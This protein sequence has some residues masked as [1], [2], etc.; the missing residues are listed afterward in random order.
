MVSTRRG[1]GRSGAWFG[2]VSAVAFLVAPATP[3]MAGETPPNFILILT[4]DQGWGTTSVVYDPRRP[5]SKS[6]YF[7]TPSMDRL[8][9]SGMRFT[10]GYAAH[11]N[12]SPSRAAIQT[13]RSPAALHF[14]DIAGRKRGQ[15]AKADSLYK[16]NRLTP[17]EPISDLP[18][19]ALT[20]PELLKA[21]NPSYRAAHFGKWHL[22]GG[23]PGAHGYDASD[24]ATG[25]K[26]GSL[27][28]NLPDDPKQAF[29]IT[30][31]AIAWMRKQV[32]GG[33][34][35]FLQV[36]HYATHKVPQSLA[37]THERFMLAGKGERHVNADYG[38]MLYD[39]DASI[40]LLLDAVED[41]GIV[42]STFIVLTADNGTYH[43]DDPGN[44]NGP[45]RGFKGTIWEGGVRVPFIVAG[46]GIEAGRVSRVPVIGWDILP[47]VCELAGITPWPQ[48][49]EGGSMRPILFGSRKGTIRRPGDALV[50]HFPHYIHWLARKPASAIVAGDWKLRYRWE[51]GDAS[52]YDLESDLDESED[53]AP[54]HPDR[55]KRMT[56][57]MMAYLRGVGAQLP[58]P[59]PEY[60]PEND[61]ADDWREYL[62][63]RA[64][65]E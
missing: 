9:R 63:D 32:D 57:Q 25:N 42:G 36:S 38:A 51:T 13:G 7:D 44:L 6:D 1:K 26:E 35:F 23:G 60:D 10:Q 59:N 50:F 28:E 4:D 61:P 41:V 18:L 22:G 52:L 12:C 34:P 21:G 62:P 30:E 20:I 47:T 16:G 8:A 17:P 46:P 19:E 29:G 49:V 48:V 53:L 15:S 55:A 64:I 54:R 3:A 56:E 11:P 43:T 58:E 45:L 40:G 65:L 31:R 37:A 33:H 2:F 39:L 27:A 5:K 14:T 24:G